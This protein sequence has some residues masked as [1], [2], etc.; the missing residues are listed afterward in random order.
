MTWVRFPLLVVLFVLAEDSSNMRLF[1]I[2][3]SP[4][5][6]QACLGPQLATRPEDPF[7]VRRR[8]QAHSWGLFQEQYGGIWT[9]EITG[10]EVAKSGAEDSW[11]GGG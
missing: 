10:P 5:T 9:T 6:C 3:A 4:G 8:F 1:M 11:L 2:P 7:E